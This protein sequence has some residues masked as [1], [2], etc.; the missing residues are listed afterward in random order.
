V[1]KS[2]AY[3]QHVSQTLLQ[4]ATSLL[5]SFPHHLFH[6]HWLVSSFSYLCD[7][8]Q[9]SLPDS[10]YRTIVPV[11]PH[12]RVSSMLVSAHFVEDPACSVSPRVLLIANIFQATNTPSQ[13]ILKALG[14]SLRINP[15]SPISKDLEEDEGR[16]HK[17]SPCFIQ[18]P[19]LYT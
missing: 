14:N 6:R 11:Q 16:S 1:D 18:V 8:Q 4:F 5:S 9:D 12:P 15:R 13:Q 10:P 19:I 2:R 17:E 7:A 3:Q